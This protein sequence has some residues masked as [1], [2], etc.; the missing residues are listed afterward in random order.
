M[1][2]TFFF[3]FWKE[4]TAE[5]LLI[6][7]VY[8][9]VLLYSSRIQFEPRIA[10][11]TCSYCESDRTLKKLFFLSTMTETNIN[12]WR[13]RDDDSLLMKKQNFIKIQT[14]TILLKTQQLLWYHFNRENDTQITFNH[15]WQLMWICTWIIKVTILHMIHRSISNRSSNLTHPVVKV[16]KNNNNNKF[17]GP[18]FEHWNGT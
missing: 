6:R 16:I 10:Y 15:R 13:K 9:P 3:F 11:I 2:L 8:S 12:M 7:W 14:D 1:N 17:L 18:F 4:G 5:I